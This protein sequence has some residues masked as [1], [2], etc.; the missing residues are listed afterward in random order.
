MISVSLSDMKGDSRKEAQKAQETIRS[1]CGF[2]FVR[3]APFCG[4]SM[5]A[6]DDL[7]QT[8]ARLRGPG[9]CPW[10]QEQNHA[11]LVRCLI[12]EVSELIDTIDR[13]DLP[14]MREELGDVLIQ[15]VFHSRL[16]EEA[17]QF[18]FEDVAH[19]INE[20]LVRRHPHVFGTGKLDTSDQVITQWEQIKARE[21]KNGPAANAAGVFKDL[22]PR[23]P[24]LMFAE[25]VWKQIE[26]KKLPAEGFVD[27]QQVAA[28]GAQLDEEKLGRMLFELSAAARA[29][30]L[31]P[32]GALRLHTVKVMRQ[33]EQ[34]VGAAGAAA[35]RPLGTISQ[36]Q[37]A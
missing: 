31:D 24:A 16:A 15:I 1:D 20:K 23:L 18:T 32:E 36:T 19:D 5:S 11:T 14:H 27:A 22:P 37:G 26:K 30:G 29:K 12:D 6:I 7:I 28:V 3:F 9:G 35:A 33:V 21:K 8:M 25:A 34:Q 4:Q 13:N 10:D 2:P 17:G